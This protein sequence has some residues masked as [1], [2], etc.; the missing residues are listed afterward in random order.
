LSEYRIF[1]TSGFRRDLSSLGPDA[2]KRIQETLNRRVYAVLRAAPRE[3]PSAARLRDWDPPTWRI[4][5]GAW[6]IF[7]E[8]ND[9]KGIVFLTAADH[10]KDAY[11]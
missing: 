2:A 5:L 9:E 3:V 4:R 1:E 6:R 8:I 7:F 10:R 11:R